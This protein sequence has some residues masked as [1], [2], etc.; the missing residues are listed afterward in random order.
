M[1][2]TRPMRNIE[3]FYVE[4]MEKPCLKVLL[5]AINHAPLLRMPIDDY[6]RCHHAQ[7]SILLRY[8]RKQDF[9]V[10]IDCGG[11]GKKNEVPIAES[12]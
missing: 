2:M 6:T 12:K 1:I 3:M 11:G 5:G 9:A 7:A 4:C 10:N 8:V